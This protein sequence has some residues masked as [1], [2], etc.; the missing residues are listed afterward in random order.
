MISGADPLLVTINGCSS[1]TI[2]CGTVPGNTIEL[3]LS[4]AVGTGN[5]ITTSAVA[6][7]RQEWR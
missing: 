5:V 1:L 4:S 3:V 6:P 2:P 7:S